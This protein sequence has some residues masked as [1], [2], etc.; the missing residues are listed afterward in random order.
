MKLRFKIDISEAFMSGIDVAS[1]DAEIEVNPATLTQEMRDMIGP[2]LVGFDVC[3]LRIDEDALRKAR[4]GLIVAKDRD[5]RPRMITATQPT[6]EAL[7]EAIK[8]SDQQLD[9]QIAEAERIAA[10]RAKAEAERNAPRESRDKRKMKK[11]ER[12]AELPPVGA[13]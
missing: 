4:V 2:R 6:F 10:E 13:K 11:S 7:V 9:M 5:E 12:L 3:E 1:E 8:A